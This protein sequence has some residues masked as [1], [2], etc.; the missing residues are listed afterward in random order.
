MSTVRILALDGGPRGLLM[1]SML[2][3]LED[4]RPGLLDSIDIFAGTSAG[5]ISAA[6]IAAGSTPRAGLM[7]AIEFWRE[8]RPFTKPG[9]RNPRTWTALTGMSA[10]MTHDSMRKNLKA[11]LGDLRLSDLPRSLVIPSFCLDNEVVLHQRRQWSVR[12]YHNLMLDMP[13]HNDPLADIC[14]RSSS[15]PMLHPVYQGHIDGGLFANNPSLCAMVTAL[16]FAD[17]TLPQIEVLSFGQ[18]I[19]R[20]YMPVKGGDIGYSRWLLDK[21]NPVAVIKVV[22]ESNTQAINYQCGRLLE[23]RFIRFDP[24]L[25]TDVEPDPKFPIQEFND[26]QEY[27][28]SQIELD[29]VLHR[30]DALNSRNP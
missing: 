17:T 19:T 1:N 13:G 28:A 2:L 14:M 16:D 23:D 26:R 11:M 21:D 4:Q 12:V 3:R 5:S 30:F 27:M 7:R 25:S 15:I 9:R 29:Q 20:T 18:G 22:M 24:T 10:F 6:F 8:W